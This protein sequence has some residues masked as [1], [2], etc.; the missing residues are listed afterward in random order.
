MPIVFAHSARLRL[1]TATYFG[2]IDDH[3]LRRAYRSLTSRYD[4]SI[5]HIVDLT[6]VTT[7]LITEPAVAE[8]AAFCVDTGN[9]A[10]L[11][12]IAYDNVT[13]D[14]TTLLRRLHP[15]EHVNVCASLAAAREWLLSK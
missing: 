1:R 15:A 5:D 8:L 6:G 4:E 9:S 14:V 7:M 12:I 10:R 13:D 2:V 3:T 11:A